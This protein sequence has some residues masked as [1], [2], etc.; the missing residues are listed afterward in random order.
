[1]RTVQKRRCQ[2]RVEYNLICTEQK[3]RGGIRRED[4]RIGR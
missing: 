3:R 1:M 4:D 2:E